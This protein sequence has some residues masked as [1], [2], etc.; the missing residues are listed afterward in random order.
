MEPRDCFRQSIQ[1]LI[2]EGEDMGSLL[3]TFLSILNP[4]GMNLEV[5]SMVMQS[6][7]ESYKS[8]LNLML[9]ETKTET[10]SQIAFQ[11]FLAKNQT[12]ENGFSLEGDK[13]AEA[14]VLYDKRHPN[15]N[16]NPNANPNPNPIKVAM[17]LPSSTRNKIF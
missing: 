2:Q 1:Y 12:P 5:A 3:P 14:V 8:T 7:A 13:R 15:P 11:Q 6:G 10:T 17:R 4:N 16:P 9:D